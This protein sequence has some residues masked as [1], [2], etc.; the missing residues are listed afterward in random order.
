VRSLDNY[1]KAEYGQKIYKL[2]LD[3]G[4]SCPNRDGTAGRGGCSFCSAG[5]SGEFAAAGCEDISSQIENAK[6][7]VAAKLKNVK[8]KKYIAYFQAYTNTYVTSQMTKGKSVKE[9]LIELYRPVAERDDIVAISIGTRPDCLDAEVVEALSEINKIKPVWVEIGLQ[10][11]HDETAEMMNRGY[12]L[13]MFEQAYERL[14]AAG[15]KTVIHLILFWPDE[16]EED[17][18]ESIRY[19][20]GIKPF[21]VKLHLLQV[22]RGTGLAERYEKEQFRLPELEEYAMF[23]E[24]ALQEFDGDIVLHRMTGD[25]PKNILIAPL[26]CADKKK[27][28]NRLNKIPYVEK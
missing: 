24:K 11:I 17:M 28:L 23:L 26:W 12:D 14:K 9:Y 15:I 1:L 21:G 6:Q 19:V 8:D 2:S 4:F 25:G 7:R 22:L 5:G 13:K 20:S 27:V 10:T 3:A 16:T 18:L